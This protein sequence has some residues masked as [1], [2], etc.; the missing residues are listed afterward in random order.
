MFEAVVNAIQSIDATFDNLSSGKITITI[1]RTMQPF[2][3]DLA[4]FGRSAREPIIG[5]VIEDNGAGFDNENM[6][7]FQTLDSEYKQSQGCRGVGRLLWLKAFDHV[8]VES[9]YRAEDGLKCRK[10]RFS[11]EE[12][13]SREEWPAVAGSNA[14]PKT[15]VHLVN[16]HKKYQ[17]ES[18]KLP[19]TIA[20]DLL[21]HCLWYFVRQRGVPDILVVDNGETIDLKAKYSDFIQSVESIQDIEV[22]GQRFDLVHLKVQARSQ[23]V[24][25]L[26]WCAA[27]RVVISENISGKLP[28]LHGA[29]TDEHGKFT[30]SGYLVSPFLDNK[31]RSERTGFDLDEL[32]SPGRNED[33]DAFDD[34]EEV[35]ISQ[36]EI[37][38]KILSEIQTFLM[39]SLVGA[40]N[41][42][43]D[44]VEAFIENK[45]PRYRPVLQRIDENG[46]TV[47]P[48]INERELE[49]ELHK[50]LREIELEV[51]KEGQEVL[52]INLLNFDTD[53]YQER[54]KGYL[55]K[56]ED[57]KMS[58]LAGYVSHRKVIIE[59]LAKAIEKQ[60]DEKYSR[61]DVVHNLIMSMG[62]T[63]NDASFASNNLWLIDER[64]T[65]HNYLASDK[66]LS[67]MP[68][69]GSASTKEPDLFAVR[70]F[71]R[72]LIADGEPAK[73]ASISIIEIKRPMRNDMAAGSEKDPI[74][75]CLNYL[76]LVRAGIVRTASG[77]PVNAPESIPA[78]CYVIADLTP[79]LIKRCKQRD[80]TMTDDGIGYFGYNKSF[81]AYVE[82]VSFDRLLISARQRNRAFFDVLGLTR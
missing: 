8:D 19:D 27:N 72:V 3:G 60:D 38:E 9:I 36:S 42:I 43:R 32:P 78:F 25:Q 15:I 45:A 5:F 29:L 2:P 34:M 40:Q 75:Q 57:I 74:E 13:I 16:F 7:S 55:A 80:L 65:F 33:Q 24:P 18:R 39:A 12:G 50:G 48:K 81:N 68:V 71:D 66:T 10:F 26:N 28:G 35:D 76:E 30:Y 54:L 14:A 17:S 52:D 53:G 62:T 41:D 22:R 82:V 69:T 47:D 67:A 70:Q 77:R 63:S 59:I 11:T 64:L 58:D 46:F 23:D 4:T 1:E 73:S 21:E 44:R 79:S 51:L 20:R 61:E 6:Q 37:R 49:L 31:V 56:V